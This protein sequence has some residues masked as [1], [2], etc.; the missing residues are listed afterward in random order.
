M[1][2]FFKSFFII[3][4]LFQF[5]NSFCVSYDSLFK[6]T[7]KNIQFESPHAIY[8]SWHK[9]KLNFIDSLYYAKYNKYF[10]NNYE[11]ITHKS[12]IGYFRSIID[13]ISN[14]KLKELL[15]IIYKKNKISLSL[16]KFQ[17]IVRLNHIYDIKGKFWIPG[18][19]EQYFDSL[20]K[21]PQKYLSLI[22]NR[23]KAFFSTHW[24]DLDTV[25]ILKNDTINVP[26]IISG[27]I[28]F[29]IEIENKILKSDLVIVD[30]QIN[31][32]SI[33]DSYIYGMS[34]LNF[35]NINNFFVEKT[36]FEND[37]SIL[38]SDFKNF[39][40]TENNFKNNVFYRRVKFNSSLYFYKNVFSHFLGLYDI[41]TPE[42]EFN[43][44]LPDA[45]VL[46]GFETNQNIILDYWTIKGKDKICF[47]NF[48]D[49]SPE[50]ISF[51]PAGFHLWFDEDI[52][53]DSKNSFYQKLLSK[54]QKNYLKECFKYLDIQYQE[55]LNTDYR[56]NECCFIRGYYLFKNFLSNT[57]WKYGYSKERIILFTIVFFVIFFILNS[58][59][60]KCIFST[61]NIFSDT[62]HFTKFNFVKI[63]VFT[64]TIYFGFKIAVNK[65]KKFNGVMVYLGIIYTIGTICTGFLI[66]YILNL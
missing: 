35:N 8:S 21:N 39:N 26:V 55:F 33:Y 60:Y 27:K 31:D 5:N 43:S 3:L 42:F 66:K 58:I 32:F 23:D 45:L 38:C 30:C 16:D 34:F 4:F 37:V 11:F 15:K 46:S 19:S 36:T 51:N 1:S 63:L 29:K 62:N 18:S 48:S 59:F 13:T 50:S 52:S 6:F 10:N 41:A 14:S 44:F 40:C 53:I 64:F 9:P 54:Y 28:P 22:R 20:E 7:Y 57:W 12:G 47:V 49:L 24:I 65:I 25:I 56:E 61:Y 17:I 2:L